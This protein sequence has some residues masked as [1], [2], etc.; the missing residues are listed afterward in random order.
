MTGGNNV[1]SSL[2]DEKVQTKSKINAKGAKII[3]LKE[4]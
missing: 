3:S 1:A 2:G 4:G